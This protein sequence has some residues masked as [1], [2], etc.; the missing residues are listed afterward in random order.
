LQ[1]LC[2]DRLA[3]AAPCA[4]D[5]GDFALQSHGVVSKAKLRESSF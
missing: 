1:K 2:G 5:D 3:N 4:C